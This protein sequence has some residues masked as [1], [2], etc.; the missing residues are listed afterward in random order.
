MTEASDKDTVVNYLVTGTAGPDDYVVLSGSVTIQAGKTSALID[1]ETI[2]SDLLEDNESVIVT[3]TGTSDGDV[4][5]HA[6]N[7]TAA[8]TIADDDIATVGITANISSASEPDTD[9]QF[10]VTLSDASDKDTTV[11][12]TASGTAGAGDDYTALSGSITISA[13]ETTATISVEAIDDSVLEDTETVIVTLGSTSDSDIGIDT[14]AAA[15]TITI[16]DDDMA[17]VSI[18]ATDADASEPSDDGLLAVSMS[19]TSDKDTVIHYMVSGTADSGDDFVTL[20]NS[21]TIAAGSTSAAIIIDTVDDAVLEDSETLIVTLLG[22]SDTDVSLDS[23][24]QSATVV[25]ADNDSAT[26]AIT[27]NDPNSAEP[28]DDG[29]FTVT[30]STSSDKDTVVSYNVTGTADSG[31]DYVPL[32]GTVT[33]SAG[34]TAAMI[35][36]DVVDSNLLEDMENVIVTLT[37]TSDLDVALDSSSQSAMVT[38]TDD[39]KAM[40]AI[41]ANDATASEP[42]DHGQFTIALS[43][44]SDKATV[45]NYIVSGTADAGDDYV[46]I[47]ASVTIAAGETT[48]TVDVAVLDE[49]KLEEAETVTLLLTGTDDLDI[50]VDTSQNTATVVIADDDTA[51]VAIAANDPVAAEP[52]D[53]GQFTVT[54]SEASDKDTE[55][56]YLATG[57]ADGGTDFTTLPGTVTVLAGETT[58]TIDVNVVDS[59]LLE[60]NE[61]VIVTLVRTDDIDVDVDTINASAT[62][63]IADDDKATVTITADDASASEPND[64]G[65]FTVTMSAASDKDTVVNYTIAGTAEAGADF[66][67]LSGTVTIEAGSLSAAI[68]VNAIDDTVLEDNETVI[69]TLIGTDD[70][71]VTIATTNNTSTVVVADDDTASVS[72]SATTSNA[73]E[74]NIDGAFTVTMSATSDQDTVVTY[75]VTGTADSAD[76]YIALPGTVTIAAG[77]TTAT[78]DV[79]VLDDNLVEQM[80]DVNVELMSVSDSDVSINGTAKTATVTITD[81][82][83]ARVS[84]GANILSASEPDADGQFTVTQ[85]Q[86]SDQDTVINLMVTGTATAG[87]DY[88]AIPTS[89]TILAGD[90]S[91]T[92]D[93]EVIDSD[94]L[95]ELET[96]VVTL[97]GIASADPEVT[98]DTT[99]NSAFVLIDDDDAATV[100]V[101]AS[102][103]IAGEPG[104]DGQ[105]LVTLS[106]KSDRD[107]TINYVLSGHANSGTDFDVLAG[108]VTIA[109]GDTT[110][111][112]DVKVVDDTI[113]EDNETLTLMLTGIAAGDSE[114]TVDTSAN[115][116]SVSI[117]DNDKATVSISVSDADAREPGD[118]GQFTVT[119]SAES[120]KDTEV[121]YTVTGTAE[122]GTDYTTLSGTVTIA[123]GKTSATID[124]SVL[125]DT[126]LE[127][128]ETVIVALVGTDDGD[129]SIDISNN[130]AT[131]TIAD[132]D[133]ATVL[134]T[135]SDADAAEPNDDGQFTVN[136]S[137]V[138]DKD[139]DVSYVIAGTADSGNDFVALTGTVTILKGDTSAT[140]NIQT[141]DSN[142][143][144]ETE[145][146]IV[147]LVGTSD[148]DVTVA[149][150]GNTA[151]VAIDDDDKA[152]LSIVANDADASEPG[153]DG[154]FTMTISQV[155]D[156]D[157]VVN[158][159]VTGTAT[160]GDDY[161]TIPAT[162]T[163]LAG[164]LTATIDVKT[165]DSDLL[166]DNESVIVTLASIDSADDDVS[167]DLAA[168]S[169][170]VAIVDDDKA[171][172]SISVTD[173]DAGESSN[174][175]QFTVTMSKSS[176]KDTVIGY[177]VSGSADG[178]DFILLSG[179]V[180]ILAGETIAVIEISVIDDA[181]LEGNETVILTLIGTGDPDVAVDSVSNTATITITDD[182]LATATITANDAD[183]AEPAD[184]G[185]FTVTLSNAADQDTVISYVV[186]GDATPDVDYT[187][188]SGTVTIT[189]G[190]TSARIDVSALNDDVLEND[191][192]IIVTLA[193]IDSGDSDVTI[194]G[195]ETATITLLDDDTAGVIV[196]ATGP[197]ANE[198]GVGGEFTVELS[199]LSDTDTV[200]HYAISG[201][202]APDV[203]YA[204]LQGTITIVAGETSATIN[205][206]AID[207]GLLEDGENVTITLT[208]LGAADDDIIVWAADSATVT[209]EDNDIAEVSVAAN[210]AD[211]GEAG[212]N[213]QFTI[214]L[215]TPSDTDTVVLYTIS[216]DATGD[217]DYAALPGSVTIAAGATSARIDIN[218]ID[219]NVLESTETLTIR[220]DAIDSGDADISIGSADSATV[221]IDDDDAAEATVVANDSTAGEPGDHG[222]FTVI[223]SNPSDSDTE[224]EYAI[225]G[226]ALAGT[227]YGSMTGILTIAAGELSA[228]IDVSIVDDS[229][230]ELPENVSITLDGFAAGSPNITIG[231][232]DTAS[233]SINDDD[234]TTVSIRA[235][236]ATANESG[237]N[238]QLTVT[239]SAAAP[240]DTMVTYS[241]TGS[242]IADDDYTALTGSVLFQAGQ[243]SV[244][245]D[246]TAIDNLVLEEDEA[247]VVTLTGSDQPFV[248]FDANSDAATVV[249]TDNDFAEVTIVADDADAAEATPLDHGRITISMSATSDSDTTIHYSVAGTAN[250]GDDYVALPG[251]VTIAAGDT[252]ATLDVT[253]IDDYLLELNETVIVTLDSIAGDADVSIGSA[254]AATVSIADNEVNPPTLT[255]PSVLIA[256]EDTTATFSISAKTVQTDGS[257]LLQVLI[258]GIAEGVTLS[259]GVN[260]FTGSATTSTVDVTLWDQSQLLLTGTANSDSDF[261]LTIRAIAT[262]SNPTDDTPAAITSGTIVVRFRR[263][264]RH[265]V[266]DS[267]NVR[268]WQGGR[269]DCTEHQCGALGSRRQRVAGDSNRR[270]SDRCNTQRR[271]RPGERNMA[272]DAGR[273]GW[274]DHYAT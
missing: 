141:L 143:L 26:V 246:V 73:L 179:E 47:A 102:D 17:L 176:D 180:T 57:T 230:V 178:T 259:D 104:D 46:A 213:G 188:L 140:I 222:Q 134:I 201:D 257:E 49:V 95:E 147:T 124:I 151:T 20:T 93:V 272:I 202:A 61:T 68:D 200:I 217:V 67:L 129:A 267:H 115:A 152:T 44:A 131:I 243:T 164:E 266:A 83:S 210:D 155:S 77:Q 92:I 153:D 10:T 99:A 154:Q 252:S 251:S 204:S 128:S 109:A 80:E 168:N 94:M 167:I 185:Q 248:E 163:I 256:D 14:S 225:G 42:S 194:G 137:Q 261:D 36:I 108:S 70:S 220:L 186:A 91:A 21:L 171:S 64:D 62:V 206:T 105:F 193:N 181:I 89:V 119:M 142:L 100:N 125:N 162:T 78:I 66:T 59:G 90:T 38:I 271:Q 23:A 24:N 60:D 12:Y 22:T 212:D 51:T 211:A 237:D 184:N 216:G 29:Q 258:D 233:V 113:L 5:L 135:A 239:L 58:A 126:I 82:D 209:I 157:T 103:A 172:V 106:D 32:L 45:V 223:L 150:S 3:L 268:R 112:I 159:L 72:I 48:A 118:A 265:P 34:S 244:T 31:S 208:G 250:G 76:D 177:T 136:M 7:T 145:T 269:S 71:D 231:S 170:S 122:G 53:G 39:D 28:G 75:V 149:A 227:D 232:D 174:N 138:S 234:T 255:V 79:S 270:R 144:E 117:S 43:D 187:A 27:A 221:T 56:T 199:Q 9:G 13:G 6:S 81:N 214:S 165:V 247:V 63:E 4:T 219:D 190:E 11:N 121:S 96:V 33:I 238:G 86:P 191:E 205:V 2:D 226:D 189:A 192:T 228:T 249:I 173:A 215:S 240:V 207:D 175:G 35:D 30:M 156:Q 224:I 132:N 196:T 203:D 139:T 183:A 101:A 262:S 87:D 160:T 65:R 245:I 235:N 97:N 111:T 55:I 40:V 74:Q 169:A 161:T 127:D 84:I 18:A 8:V 253:L 1:V 195:A 88:I 260:L 120:D 50:T 114:V 16:A 69:V 110:A 133:T 146:V 182:D 148:S 107:T 116:A 273:P 19:T 274:I 52:S 25:I 98:I 229:D 15:A 37:G 198:S 264:R 254:R 197:T 236:D 218:V 242:A 130:T 123:A 166:E 54:M 158:I 241:V 85:T 263:R 41:Q